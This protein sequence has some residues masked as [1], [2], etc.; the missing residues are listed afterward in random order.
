M[1]DKHTNDANDVFYFLTDITVSKGECST[2]ALE[3][4]AKRI[5][6]KNTRRWLTYFVVTLNGDML[7]LDITTQYLRR[8]HKFPIM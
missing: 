6:I 8:R 1:I 4:W 7:P 5:N 3:I 2:P